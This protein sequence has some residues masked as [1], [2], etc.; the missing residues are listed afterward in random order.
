MVVGK[1]LRLGFLVG[2]RQR[3]KYFKSRSAMNQGKTYMMM[4]NLSP[5]RN[6]YQ[7]KTK[8]KIRWS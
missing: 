1:R 3:G 8:D 4:N 2:N 5:M 7:T 6:K